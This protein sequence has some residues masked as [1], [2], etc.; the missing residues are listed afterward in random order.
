MAI[1]SE[2]HTL[3]ISTLI[4]TWIKAFNT[5]NVAGIVALYTED[6]ELL[7][8]GM[9]HPRYGKTEIEQWFTTR[10]RTMPT[11]QYT[12]HKQ[13][14]S[15]QAAVIWTTRGTRRILGQCWLSRPFQ[16]DGVSIFTTRNGLIAKQHGYY[17]NLSA[18]EQIFPPLKRLLPVRL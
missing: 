14:I 8:S 12:P 2:D 15:E 18:L 7:D 10:F 11:I 17:D 4:N 6:A 3:L 13:I 16:V 9:K 1:N 5:H